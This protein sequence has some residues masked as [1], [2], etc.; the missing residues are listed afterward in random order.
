M[1]Q[2]IDYAVNALKHDSRT[3]TKEGEEATRA[4]LGFPPAKSRVS[5]SDRMLAIVFQNAKEMKLDEVPRPMITHPQDA[6]IHV[7]TTTICGSDLHLFNKEWPQVQANEILGH[8]AVG[9]VEEVGP[10][11]KTLKKGDKVVISAVIACG[12]CEYCQREQYSLCDVSNPSADQEKMYGHRIA[13]L[14]GATELMGGY[15]GCQ[16]EYVRVPLADV[17]CLRV[18]DSRLG[19][20]KL[21]FLSDVLLT[22]WHANELGR[23]KEG[24]KV[25]VFGLGPIGLMSAYLAKFRK[26]ALVVGVE[27]VPYRKELA[28]SHG[29]VDTVVDF[30][31]EDVVSRIQELI[32]GGPD[33][34]IDATA[35]RYT[36]GLLHRVQRAMRLETDSPEVLNECLTV[37][38]KGGIVVAI[39]DYYAYTNNFNIGALMEKSV[40]LTGGQLFA[41]KYWHKLR[42]LMESGQIDPSWMVSHHLP[43]EDGPRAYEVFNKK[44]EGAVKILLRTDFETT[45]H[46]GY[47]GGGTT[48]EAVQTSANPNITSRSAVPGSATVTEEGTVPGRWTSYREEVNVSSSGGAGGSGGGTSHDLGKG[49]ESLRL[50]SQQHQPTGQQANPNVS[51]LGLGSSQASQA[52]QA[53]SHEFIHRPGVHESV[54][55][56][57][58]ASPPLD[59]QTDVVGQG[60]ERVRSVAHVESDVAGGAQSSVGGTNTSVLRPD[61]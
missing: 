37:V 46:A 35:F 24:D 61:Y 22:G 9:I 1:S 59:E 39:A 15:S 47:L 56:P 18:T 44:E 41:Q 58:P 6:I 7:T 55:H 49:I 5:Q 27:T 53:L 33:V 57:A 40:T 42:S 34:C 50:S 30:R 20:D 23:V 36:E 60:G 21:I 4:K 26:A 43:L 3:V 12:A 31:T 8:E 52:A 28:L 45:R 19:D 10:L 17:N 48:G 32:P 38:K 13:G 11:C 29:R 14:F 16:A 51:H 2:F 25:V 54:G